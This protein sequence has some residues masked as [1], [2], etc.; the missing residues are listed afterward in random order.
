MQAT[1]IIEQD[2]ENPFGIHGN[3]EILEN[4]SSSI[5]LD[6]DITGIVIN[7]VDLGKSRMED[8]RQ[9]QLISKEI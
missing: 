7:M 4:I 2:Y 9:K 3:K 8:F 5:A 1:E 6:D